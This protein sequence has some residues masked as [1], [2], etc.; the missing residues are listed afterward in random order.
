MFFYEAMH[1]KSGWCAPAWGWC[2]WVRVR[3]QFCS[4]P[5]TSPR[6]RACKPRTIGSS[7]VNIEQ[8]NGRRKEGKIEKKILIKSGG[9]TQYSTF[10]LCRKT[11]FSNM[12]KMKK[13]KVKAVQPTLKFHHRAMSSD[14]NW[15]PVHYWPTPV[16]WR[17]YPTGYKIKRYPVGYGSVL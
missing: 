7:S 13:L 4:S 1:V 3:P 15:Y 17:K 16:P 14:K 5:A 11:I 2:W 8:R 6:T 10:S 9:Y 12:P